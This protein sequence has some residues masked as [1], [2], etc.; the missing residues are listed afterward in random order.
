MHAIEKPPRNL[1]KEKGKY[2]EYHKS[3]THDTSECTV[4]KREVEEKQMTG[5]LVEVV[6]HLRS[7]FEA[8]HKEV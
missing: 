5:D 3:K 2:Y 1:D 6:K 4:L 8:D 7:K